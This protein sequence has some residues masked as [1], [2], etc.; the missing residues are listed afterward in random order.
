MIEAFAF[1]GFAL[2]FDRIARALSCKAAIQ[3]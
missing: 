1:D 3:G 2:V